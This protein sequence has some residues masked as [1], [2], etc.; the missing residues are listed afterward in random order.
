MNRFDKL[1]V[2]RGPGGRG[3]KK[4]R[5]QPHAV[6]MD[7]G[8]R[9]SGRRSS[10]TSPNIILDAYYIVISS[11]TIFLETRKRHYSAVLN[12][13]S[14]E[15]RGGGG[16][17]RYSAKRGRSAIPYG[18]GGRAHDRHWR[19]ALTK[20]N[21]RPS[22]VRMPPAGEQ[23][24]DLRSI[25]GSDNDDFSTILG[26]QVIQ[27]LWREPCDSDELTQLMQAAL[28]AMIGMKP[29]DELEGMLIAQL[30]AIHNAAM[31][32]YRRAMIGE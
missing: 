12:H 28:A 1:T 15:R 17:W 26:N 10:R 18:R 6:P 4:I 32:C 27:A 9:D 11:N 25:S 14:G 20:T 21:K 19:L 30:I 24:G 3:H 8:G 22:I 2:P 29:R 23:R 16:T 31:E 13:R 5:D 7:S